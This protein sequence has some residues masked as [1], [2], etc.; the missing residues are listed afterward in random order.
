MPRPL[1]A[2]NP[3]IQL[4]SYCVPLFVIFPIPPFPS[5]S[6]GEPFIS[7]TYNKLLFSSGN[8]DSGVATTASVD[9]SGASECFWPCDTR[10]AGSRR[11]VI[12]FFI[13]WFFI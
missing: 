2:F 11:Q 3:V 13:C 9:H 6:Q 4:E 10:N 12:I 1:G 5:T 7:E 8:T